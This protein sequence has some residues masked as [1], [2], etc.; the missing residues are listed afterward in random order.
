MGEPINQAKSPVLALPLQPAPP[1]VSE[2]DAD[3]AEPGRPAPKKAA[4]PAAK[5]AEKPA[6]P[7]GGFSSHHAGGA[8]FA[9]GDGSV[10]FLKATA[11]P[12]ILQMLANRNDGEMISADQF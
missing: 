1:V 9:F 12:K 10:R 2:E 11:S 7:V 5:G 6:D 4:A 8:N 3:E